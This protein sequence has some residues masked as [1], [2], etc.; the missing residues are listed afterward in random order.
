M[1]SDAKAR[2]APASGNGAPRTG[3]PALRL[4]DLVPDRL[5]ANAGTERGGEAIRHSLKKLGAGR[6][7]VLDRMGRIIAGNKTVENARALGL[8]DLIVVRTDGKK[9]VAV[10]RTDLDLERDPNARELAIADNR[11]GQLNLEWAGDILQSLSSAIDLTA[12][13]DATELKKLFPEPTGAATEGPEPK[14]D[15]ADELQRKW[16]TEPGQLWEIPGARGNNHR[17]RCGDS[18]SATDMA[19]LMDGKKAR[20]VFTDPP[21]NVAIGQDSNPRHR[22]R[23]GLQNDNLSPQQFGEFIHDFA[24]HL[25]PSV[26]GDVYCILGASEWPTLDRELR[27]VGFHWSA[28]VIWVKDQFVLGRSKYHRRYEPLW[29]GWHSTGK[30]SFGDARDLDDV[31]EIPRPKVSEAHPTMKPVALPFRAITNS[32][33]QGD[34]VLEPFVGGGSTMVASEQLARTCYA[35]EKDPRFVA[36]TLQ[37]MADNG[38]KPVLTK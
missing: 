38:L 10:Q 2:K 23:A 25:I 31:W 7:L 29:Y 4:S 11:T 30:S 1:N 13:F 34:I 36:V 6:S 27:A 22:Q 28:T 17:L 18:T 19:L 15:L 8:D 9:L 35:M 21:W 24:T 14:V 5:N 20:M 32:S 3:A 33:L 16:N 26:E 37:R 12:Y